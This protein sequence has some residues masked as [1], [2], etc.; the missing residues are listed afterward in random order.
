MLLFKE[1][2]FMSV[3]LLQVVLFLFL[4][5]DAG[6]F[7]V[8]LFFELCSRFGEFDFLLLFQAGFLGVDGGFN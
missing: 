3:L 7:F 4:L 5:L 8:M 2:F 6:F 1:S